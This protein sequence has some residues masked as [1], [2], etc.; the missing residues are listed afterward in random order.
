M[1]HK[2][3]LFH[4]SDDP[5]HEPETDQHIQSAEKKNE[6]NGDQHRYEGKTADR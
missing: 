1:L 2:F 4:D 3:L 5:M 6:R